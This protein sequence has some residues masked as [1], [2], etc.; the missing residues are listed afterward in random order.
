M[1]NRKFK[2]KSVLFTKVARYKIFWDESYKTTIALK[3][4]K[5]FSKSQVQRYLG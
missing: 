4:G 1:Y 2:L 5:Y 3:T